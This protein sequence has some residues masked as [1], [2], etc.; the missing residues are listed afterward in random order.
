M[1]RE[2]D[3]DDIGKKTP[4]RTPEHFF[5]DMQRRVMERVCDGQ[6]RKRRLRRMLSVAVA[7]AAILVGVL[8]VPPYLRTEDVPAGTSDMLAADSGNGEQVDKWIQDLSD[9]ELKE[10][11]DFSESDIFLN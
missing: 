4:Y 7:A 9:E 5:E 6:Q 3:F 8:L 10:L 11:I 1:D 2:F